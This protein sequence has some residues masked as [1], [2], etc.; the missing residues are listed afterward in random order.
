MGNRILQFLT[1]SVLSFVTV[2]AG[3]AADLSPVYKA[4][5]YR[6]PPP[7]IGRSYDW[8]GLYVGA[9]LGVGWARSGWGDVVT[10]CGAF[11]PGD[12]FGCA[13]GLGSHTGTGMLGG[14]QIGFNFQRNRMVFGVEADYSFASLRSSHDWL[15]SVVGSS[16]NGSSTFTGMQRFATSVRDPGTIAGR[17]GVTTGETGNTLWFVNGLVMVRS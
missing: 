10:D 12:P 4:P 11:I 3:V 16:P 13:S 5:V 9:H 17:L 8:G 6:A 14:G 15:G 7:V 1:A 2:Q